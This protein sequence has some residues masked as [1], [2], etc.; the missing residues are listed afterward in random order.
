M[1]SYGDAVTIVHAPLTDGYGGQRVRDWANATRTEDVP[2]SVQPISVT[3]ESTGRQVTTTD[4]RLFV[5][6]GITEVDRVEWHGVTYDVTGVE[7][8][9]Q[10]GA[11]DHCEATITVSTEVSV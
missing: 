8:F 5:G 6:S 2:A 3:E 4:K 7:D 11:F 10:Q 9:Y 1:N